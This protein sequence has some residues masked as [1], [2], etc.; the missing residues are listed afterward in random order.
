MTGQR[1]ASFVLSWCVVAVA[2]APGQA[3]AQAT[4]RPASTFVPTLTPDGQPDLQGAWMDTN[5][6]PL[7]R[8]RALAGV[9]A[10]EAN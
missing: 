8:P 3:A 6:T 4:K 9:R 2:W 1:V 5:V 10:E 7:E